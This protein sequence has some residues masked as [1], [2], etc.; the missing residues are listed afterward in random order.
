MV[1]DSVQKLFPD[2]PSGALY[3]FKSSRNLI[4]AV[5]RWGKRVARSPHSSGCVLVSTPWP[6]LT[7]SARPGAAPRAG[8]LPRV[9]LT[10]ALCVPMVAQ[11]NTVGVLHL[12]F[13]NGRSSDTILVREVSGSLIND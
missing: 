4:E 10:T 6:S 13:E 11:G 3:L 8:H 9:Q 7:W 5:V 1:A 12:E 2:A